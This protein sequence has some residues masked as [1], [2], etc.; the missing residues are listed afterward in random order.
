V[1]LG[2][3]WVMFHCS[4]SRPMPRGG[5]TAVGM[6]SSR[7][8]SCDNRVATAIATARSEMRCRSTI[9]NNLS[10][11]FEVVCSSFPLFHDGM[12][13]PGRHTLLR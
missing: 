4:S 8:R 12:C 10:F 3:N 13:R 11:S 5:H 6:R 2:H 7:R 1:S 9:E